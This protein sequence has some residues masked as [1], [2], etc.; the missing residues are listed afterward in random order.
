MMFS[1]QEHVFDHR[2]HFWHPLLIIV[3]IA[4]DVA[5]F[6]SDEHRSES[7]PGLVA[8]PLILRPKYMWHI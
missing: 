4:T 6:H 2:K 7:H 1:M 8:Y 3:L 5:S